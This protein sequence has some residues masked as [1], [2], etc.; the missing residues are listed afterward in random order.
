MSTS[1]LISHELKSA[2]QAFSSGGGRITILTG[3]GISAES[4]I[5]TFRGPEGYWSVGSREYHPQEMAT[6]AMFQRQPLEVWK[7]YL[8]RYSVC[9]AAEPNPGHMAVVEMEKRFG[10]RFTLITQNVDGLHLRAGNSP[11]RTWQ[12]HGNVSFMRCS[13]ECTDKLY[14]LPESFAG[15]PRIAD[16]TAPEQALLTCPACGSMTRPHVLWFDETYDEPRYRFESSIQAASETDLLLVVGT[17]GA[18]ALPSHIVDIATRRKEALVV[19]INIEANPFGRAAE[20]SG[21]HF[22]Q[23]PGGE[24][25]PLVLDA[26]S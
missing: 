26:L 22:L 17:S 5:P 4:G 9:R 10:D 20:R 3:A 15:R 19:D 1:P 13:A 18:T 16:I 25:L 23:A 8:Y 6:W 21:G 2:L 7:W 12:I 11:E 14:D 24:A